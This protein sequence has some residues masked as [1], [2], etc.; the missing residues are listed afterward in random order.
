MKKVIYLVVSLIMLISFNLFA[1]TVSIPNKS[2]TP[3]STVEIPVNIDNASNV[4]GFK[5]KISFN[6]NVLSIKEVVSGS[7]TGNW[8]I[9]FNKNNPGLVIIAGCPSNNQ[10]LSGSGS[11]CILKFDVIG[12]IGD[13]SNL[14]F[15]FSQLSDIS[16]QLIPHS[17]QNGLFNVIG[18]TIS[19]KV[20][21]VGGS[22]SVTSVVL[23]LTGTIT[24]TTNPDSSG[25]Y[26]F[27]NLP[28]G[29]YTI[30]PSLS[31]YVF[32]PENKTYTNLNTNVSNADFTGTAQYTLTVSSNYGSPSPPTGTNTYLHG[33][34][35][36]AS[37]S[38]PVS[39][40]TGIR[41][42]CSGWTGT[43]SV[44]AS[45]STNSL[46]FTITQ[47]STLTWNWKTEYKLTKISNPSDGG[48]IIS[49]NN[50]EWYQSNST[51]NV[52]ASPNNGYI[53]SNWS[54]DLTGT[55]N[56]TTITMT[57]PKT[58]TAN[59]LKKDFTIS[60]QPEIL[61][62]LL[63]GS[64]I[65]KEANIS[66]QPINNFSDSVS[67]SA[68][69][70]PSSNYISFN[71]DKNSII[72]SETAKINFSISQNT[73]PDTYIVTI[74]AQSQNAS[75][76]FDLKLIINTKVYLPDISAVSPSTV[77]IP[78]YVSN[79]NRIS[80]FTFKISF[81]K[82]ILSFM[83]AKIGSLTSGWTISS[84][85]IEPG[86]ISVSGNSS[87]SLTG[88]GSLCILKFNVSGSLNSS[89]NINFVL[90]ELKD[91]NNTPIPN[92]S[93]G[94]I[95]T[96]SKIKGDLNNDK[97]IDISDVILCLRMAIEIDPPDLNLADMNNDGSIDILDVILVL[98]KAIGLN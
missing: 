52:Q 86:V 23:N 38:S 60:V 11:L 92:K 51:V 73:T 14:N 32:S 27:T 88:E 42:V 50:A 94:G 31:N 67:L 56:P 81:N 6:N 83:E 36:N 16:A 89:S 90:S 17:T 34:T 87:G 72:P 69:L 91:N 4:V 15:T 76:S 29:N 7:L 53:F 82:D 80:K 59:F 13:S 8:N 39:G 96:I 1:V 77:E 65:T 64:N 47:N 25:N 9:L 45:G 35:I 24:K 37:V 44:P 54:G 20:T 30:T 98:R 85:T 10:S 12:N 97:S 46:T 78:V 19:G 58:I 21:L 61:D 33:T 66:I 93:S 75:H 3:N 63:E 43:G 55:A 68:S 26:S 74:N 28:T 57:G 22:S 48:T 18:Y 95:L 2:G 84:N 49:T 70:S 41:Y 40:L 62:I 71:F 79:A 5:F